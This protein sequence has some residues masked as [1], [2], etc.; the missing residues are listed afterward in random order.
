MSSERPEGEASLVPMIFG[1]VI[2]QMISTAARI[3]LP[4]AIAGGAHTPNE[5]ADT[6]GADRVA[7]HRLLRALAALGIVIEKEPGEFELSDS[8]QC[9]RDDVD[10]SLRGLAMVPG[11]N[12]IWAAWGAM[13]D[14]VRSGRTGFDTVHGVGLFDYLEQHQDTAEVF[15]RTMA[16]NTRNYAPAIAT[17][18]DFTRFKNIVDVGGGDGTLL[19]EVLRA[20]D[21]PRGIVLD[22]ELAVS[23]APAVL[24]SFGVADRCV[25]EPGDFF[26]SAPSGADAY[27]LKNV[28]NDW[29]DEEC[30]VILRNCRRAMIPDGSVLI[31]A[32]IMPERSGTP[33]SVIPAMA[34]IEM[35]VTTGGRERTVD[36]CR[37][38]FDAT[39]F[40]LGDVTELPAYT[41]FSVIEALPV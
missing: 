24:E 36:D 30:V 31:V 40:R 26:D 13:E 6:A 29:D 16:I 19:A 11:D 3:R 17:G 2:S 7:V 14:T 41:G 15:H 33:E 34:D 4:D 10:N 39:G 5:I 23:E 9:L 37:Q 12:A 38:L 28:L 21:G 8:G 25:I 27:L 20:N 22:V 35:L 18:Y 32:P 1:Y